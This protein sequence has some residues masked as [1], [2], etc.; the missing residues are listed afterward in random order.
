MIVVTFAAGECF[1]VLRRAGYH[2]ATLLGLV[3]TVSLMVGA[4]A[5]GVAALPAGAG[6]DHRHSP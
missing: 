3:G 2:P 5:K 4:Y 1:G 6:P